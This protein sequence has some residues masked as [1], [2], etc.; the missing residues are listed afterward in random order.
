M[1]FRIYIGFRALLWGGRAA[2][3]WHGSSAS[4]V[5]SMCRARLSS[6]HSFS[7]EFVV[8]RVILTRKFVVPRVI[9]KVYRQVVPAALD[10][11]YRLP[12]TSWFNDSS[13][14]LPD[15]C[16]MYCFCTVDSLSLLAPQPVLVQC[17][18]CDAELTLDRENLRAEKTCHQI[19]G[20]DLS[21]R[22][23]TS[24]V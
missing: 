16:P 7:R 13:F 9:S 1:G 17:S 23:Q 3:M 24:Q 10:H 4:T 5:S 8:S 15:W 12:P 11:V 2:F 14:T 19:E 20:S 22:L 21:F 18:C 6:R